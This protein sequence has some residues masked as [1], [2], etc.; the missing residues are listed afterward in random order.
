MR[1]YGAIPLPGAGSFVLVEDVQHRIHRI[2]ARAVVR[3][4]APDTWPDPFPGSRSPGV[5]AL[6]AAIRLRREGHLIWHP[7][8]AILGTG[9]RA[10]S[11]GSSLLESG[12]P[13]VI[14]METHSEWGAKRFAGWEVERRRFEMRGGRVVEA[15]PLRMEPKSALLWNFH[16]QDQQGPQSMEVARVVSAG[17]F[18]DLP[19]VREH[20]PGSLLFELDQ[21]AAMTQAEDVEGWAVEMEWGRFLAGKIA[22][23]LETEPTELAKVFHR[24][25]GRLKR[26]RRHRE[27]PFT[28]AYEGKWISTN[29]AA[30]MRSF[31][32][33][34]SRVYRNR[35]VASVECFE[36]IPCTLCQDSCP[37]AAIEPGRVLLEDRCTACGICLTACPS[38]SIVMLQENEERSFSR[39]TVSDAVSWA[40]GEFATLLNRRGDSL[41]S[42]RVISAQK[43]EKGG[44]VELEVP[45]HLLWEARAI[46]KT[47]TATVDPICETVS[48]GFVEVTLNG[49]RR[50]V[51]E[52]A[53]LSVALFEIGR[54]RAEDALL[55]PDGSCGLCQ[56][57]VD[58]VKRL[59]CQTRI[60]KGMAIVLPN[61]RGSENG[62]DRSC[63][64][65]PCLGITKEQV[66]ERI[67][68]GKLQSPEAVLSMIPIGEGKCHGQ[69]CM[70]AFRRLLLEEG[71]DASQWIDWR[72]PSSE[73]T[74]DPS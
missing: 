1:V 34:P 46:R 53:S 36:E 42:A 51:P 67:R 29:D 57:R 71:L 54:N 66:I 18:R 65:C 32:G 58:G 11:F 7:S 55:C 39:L 63:D 47:T 2:H 50:L 24:A 12:T 27:N 35:R 30:D 44:C 8:V 33:V 13:L 64:L 52:G 10:L 9:N 6:S 38:S 25:K 16:Y 69:L 5:V 72:F 22:R 15:K 4:A 59:A 17:P 43:K 26:Y 74:L 49:E 62:K 61:E 23:A 60:R 45:T 48:E 73:W 40:P 41:G 68:H 37:E 21:T 20:P 19:G 14:C 28:P 3:V 70:G 56:L 31:H